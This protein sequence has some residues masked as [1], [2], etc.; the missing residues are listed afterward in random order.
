MKKYIFKILLF[1]FVFIIWFILTN[2]SN[3]HQKESN[4]A[5]SL[6][7]KGVLK[8]KGGNG[9]YQWIEIDNIKGS[10]IIDI[11]KE[12]YN[13]GFPSWYNYE[14]GDSVLKKANSNELTIKNG[15]KKAIF[16]L[17]CRSE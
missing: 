4:K 14:V 17:D 8:G 3:E 6:G 5:Y 7:F 10:I 1:L 13:N 9:T 11:I 12:S 2:K 15:N 16:I